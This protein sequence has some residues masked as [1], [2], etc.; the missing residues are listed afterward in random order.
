MNALP[1]RRPHPKQVLPKCFAN[2][3]DAQR[4]SAAHLNGRIRRNQNARLRNT[5][6]SRAAVDTH[7]CLESFLVVVPTPAPGSICRYITVKRLAPDGTGTRSRGEPFPSRHRAG[8]GRAGNVSDDIAY[9]CD[10]PCCTVFSEK[11]RAP[12]A[13]QDSCGT[14]ENAGRHIGRPILR[15][16]ADLYSAYSASRGARSGVQPSRAWDTGRSH[17]NGGRR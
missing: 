15:V 7:T 8:K 12:A 10:R 13:R 1:A 11:W 2:A 9:R 16:L 14:A 5:P 3:V 4:V 6:S 17:V